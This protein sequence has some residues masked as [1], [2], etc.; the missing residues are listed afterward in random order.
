MIVILVCQSLALSNYFLLKEYHNSNR[1][2][3]WRK[4][5]TIIES[6]HENGDEIMTSSYFIAGRIMNYY[7]NISDKKGYRVDSLEKLKGG[8]ADP[9]KISAKRVWLI[10]QML[11]DRVFPADY[12][13][14]VRKKLNARYSMV[15]DESFVP[16]SQTLVSQLPI[17][18][19]QKGTVR[20]RLSLYVKRK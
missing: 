8:Q 12:I 19:H 4:V 11:D 18:R 7:L 17:N 14:R 6:K 2:E 3:P 16:Y 9:S 13:D 1:M 10:T 15:F 20:L 5:T